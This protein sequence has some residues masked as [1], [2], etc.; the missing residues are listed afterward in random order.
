MTSVGAGIEQIG[1]N[2]KIYIK[3]QLWFINPINP[4]SFT[5]QFFK[6]YSTYS[7]MRKTNFALG[8]IQTNDLMNSRQA[9][10][11]KTTRASL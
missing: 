1:I 9:S 6:F 8:G 7:K 4:L 2:V 10:Y 11:R 3:N 5:K